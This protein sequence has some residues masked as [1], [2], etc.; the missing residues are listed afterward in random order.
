MTTRRPFYWLL[1]AVVLALGLTAAAQDKKDEER[2]GTVTGVV[3][4]KGEDKAPVWIEVKADGEEKARKY[5]V[6]YKGGK[7]DDMIAQIKKTPLNSRVRL[8]WEFQERP[9]VV[10]LEVLKKGDGKEEKKEEARKGSVTG[11]VTGND[12]K[13]I[14]VK[15][16]G[17]EKAR[18][19]VPHWRGGNPNQGGGLDKEMIA[20]LKDIPVGS[21]VRLEWEFD[22]RARVV[23][24]E[25]LKKAEPEK[26]K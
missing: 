22:E 8:E 9:R 16:D 6:M 2:K 5:T 3:T 7:A 13:S 14:E 24:L 10:K 12:G 25:V 19:Y 23:K 11:V 26:K 20:K 17:E 4:A 1:S 18:K 21:R 15:G